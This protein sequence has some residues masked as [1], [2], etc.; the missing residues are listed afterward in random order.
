MGAGASVDFKTASEDELKKV[1]SELSAEDKVK[2]ASMLSSEGASEEVAKNIAN[3]RANKGK[4]YEIE[5]KVMENKQL[6]YGERAFI[7]ENRALILKNYSAAFMGNRQ[8][9]NENTDFIFKNRYAILK[10]LKTTTQVEVNFRESKINESKVD[11]L[12]H[13]SKLNAKVEAVSEKM[14]A[15]NALLIEIN[16]MIM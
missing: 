9:I 14:A 8:M 11:F 7:E 2:Y 10:T 1:A 6:I 5:Q 16:D 3:I 4:L 15:A 13:R 12:D